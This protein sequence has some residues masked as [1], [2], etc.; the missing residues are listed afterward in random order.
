MYRLSV[1]AIFKNESHSMSEWIKHYIHHGVEHFYLIDDNSNDSYIN[2]LQEY[3]DKG[4][5]T[6]F[7]VQEPY[8]LGRQRNLYNRHILPRIKETKWLLMVD[9]DEYVWSKQNT[10]L[11]ILLEEFDKFGQIQI[12]EAIFGSNGHETQPKYIVPSF[13]KRDE[14]YHNKYKYFVNSSFEFSSLNLH[15][16]DFTDSKYT[17]DGAVF[18]IAYTK[19]FVI[20]HYNC[21]SREFYTEV[22]CKR[23]DCD[24]YLVRTPEMFNGIDLNIVED[25][26]LLEQNKGLYT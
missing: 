16:A 2:I 6:L 13:T 18:I 21:Q 14:K 22:K 23:G 20:N 3:I 24:N 26:E 15:H 17:N 5:V 4:I 8:Y 1:G 25:T 19:Y 12:T 10:R 11:D 7:V 9:L